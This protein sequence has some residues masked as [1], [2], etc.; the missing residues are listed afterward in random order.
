MNDRPSEHDRIVEGSLREW[1]AV[2]RPLPADRDAELQ[3]VLEHIHQ[4]PGARRR[5]QRWF[6]RDALARR[7]R[8]R[9]DLA[10]QTHLRRDRLMYSA[11]GLVAL[12]AVLALAVNVTTDTTDQPPAAGAAT[13]SVA[14]DGSAD[15]STIGDALE[16]AAEGDTI[17]V[18]PGTYQEALLIDKDVTIRGDGPREEIVITGYADPAMWPADGERECDYGSRGLDGCAVLSLDSS[19]VI[20]DLTFH[21]D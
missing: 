2:E 15:H 5:L 11:T 7:R 4:A 17:L 14:A 18:A 3:A 8:E 20:S 6:G 13:L 16:A 21:G 12:I 9:R 1:L 10:S 19:V